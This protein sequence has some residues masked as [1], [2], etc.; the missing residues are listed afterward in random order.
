[1][2]ERGFDDWAADYDAHLMRGLAVSRED[3]DFFAR[4]RVAALAGWWRRTARF[5][6]RRILDFGCGTGGTAGLLADAFPG[7]SVLGLDPS[8]RMI[9]VA[10]QR[11][12]DQRV[13]FDALDPSAP[14]PPGEAD[15]V[16]LNGILHHVEVPE[17]P[18]LLAQLASALTVGGLLAIFENNPYNPGT[19]LVMSRI[20]FDR[21]ARMLRPA[22]LRV[23]L[24]EAGLEPLHTGFYFYFPR[25]LKLLRRLEPALERVPLGA[26][27]A[28]LAVP[29]T[30]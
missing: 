4:G 21:D 15:L 10:Q 7:S 5:A 8:P 9:A 26:Q 25:A 11:S 2:S 16:Y 12:A 17:R 3:R 13:R 6:P 24:R 20:P 14:L 27:Y 23:G 1:V 28:V 30:R 29:L 22:E 18:R 19:R